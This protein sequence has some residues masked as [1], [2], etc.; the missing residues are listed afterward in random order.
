M[1]RVSARIGPGYRSM[2]ALGPGVGAWLGT[3]S[4][5]VVVVVVVSD[6]VSLSEFATKRPSRCCS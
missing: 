5:V 4:L 6:S 2:V 3:S 1:F